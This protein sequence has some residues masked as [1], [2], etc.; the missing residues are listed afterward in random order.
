RIFAA[1]QSL[2]TKTTKIRAV[3]A[4][5]SA[6]AP[7][8]V[9]FRRSKVLLLLR[10]AYFGLQKHFHCFSEAFSAFKRSFTPCLA[11]FW[12]SKV[13]LLLRSAYFGLQKCFHCLPEAFLGFKSSLSQRDALLTD[14]LFARNAR[15][16]PQGSALLTEFSCGKLVPFAAKSTK[17]R[18]YS[19]HFQPSK[20]VSI[21]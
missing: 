15:I 11:C 6:F 18:A 10:S 12:R 9:R 19:V 21:R 1:R 5:K 17:I 7:C 3:L 4:F 16:L 2:A 13:L 20:A 14:F 8:L